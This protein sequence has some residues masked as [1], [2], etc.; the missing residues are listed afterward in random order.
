M[1]E[2]CEN[3]SLRIAITQIVQAALADLV[4]VTEEADDTGQR[5]YFVGIEFPEDGDLAL[6]IECISLAA[7]ERAAYRL[8]AAL[9]AQGQ[10]WMNTKPEA[11][12]KVGKGM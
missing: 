6:V 4:Q 2:I 5:H 10:R 12:T 8:R 1:M 7:A 11:I 9:R 3:T